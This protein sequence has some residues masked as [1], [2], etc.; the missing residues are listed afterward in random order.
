MH[1]TASGPPDVHRPQGSNSAPRSRATAASATLLIGSRT[2]TG[3]VVRAVLV[4]A[5]APPAPGRGWG[6]GGTREA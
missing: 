2:E 4:V 1:C 3:G 6:G 5:A